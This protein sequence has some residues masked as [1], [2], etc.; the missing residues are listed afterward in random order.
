VGYVNGTLLEILP[1][2]EEVLKA[3]KKIGILNAKGNEIFYNCVVFPLY[4]SKGGIINL[5]GRSIEE[6]AKV[7]HLYL[8]GKRSGLVNPAYSA[9]KRSQR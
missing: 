6:E 4:D 8:P 5:Y 2:D 1:E 3:L 7:P 9:V